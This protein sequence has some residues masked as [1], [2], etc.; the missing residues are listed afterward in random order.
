MFQA[1]EEIVVTRCQIWDTWG[2]GSKTSQQSCCKISWVSL[3]ECGEH[4]FEPRPHWNSEFPDAFLDCS[5]SS[6]CLPAAEKLFARNCRIAACTSHV[7][8]FSV[9]AFTFN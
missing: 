9:S 2:G 6:Q 1:P 4:Y 7:A 5:D 3:A 8:G